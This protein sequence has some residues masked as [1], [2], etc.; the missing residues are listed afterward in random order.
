MNAIPDFTLE[1]YLAKYEFSARYHMTASDAQT[2]SIAEIL[3]Y[4]GPNAR[5]AFLISGLGYTESWGADDV[6]H[7]VASTYD[8]LKQEDILCFAG[9]EEGIYALYRVLLDKDSHAITVVPNYQSA[10]TLPV[11]LCETTGI[12]LA[13]NENWTLDIDKVAAAIRPN[14]KIIYINFPNNPTGKILERD[15]F[16]ALIE[17]CRK[18][19]I[20]LFSD[21]VY[22]LIERDLAIRLPQVADVYEKGISLNVMS[23][24]YGLPGLR[25]GWLA[26][27][28][29]ELLD[30]C[31]R[32]K[33][34]LSIC[35]AGPSE[36]LTVI[37]LQ[38]RDK[39][40]VRNQ[41]LAKDG[42]AK[43]LSFLAEFPELFDSYTP[44][45]GV[46][47]Y[48]RYKG[49]DGVETFTQRL[50]EEAG[51]V[52]LPASVYSSTLT[53]VPTDRFRIGYGRNNID[54]GLSAFRA[55][56]KRNEV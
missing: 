9:A 56:L 31:V 28:D 33:H 45:G 5:E 22:R 8:T 29:R 12:A 15:R 17:L 11:L 10:E 14:T 1:T 50:V 16:D 41:A 43:L 4:A 30:R 38:N 40:L 42:S 26:C 3:D 23:K 53:K 39:I 49:A 19:G 24:A 6:R 21:E 7:A 44:D 2:H 34:Y 25:V 48:P 20:Y 52:L 35:N 18:H 36:R 47:M 27:K 51:V 32:Y 13:E 46:V 37:A 55:W 54:E